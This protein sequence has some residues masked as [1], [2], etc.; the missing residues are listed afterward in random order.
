MEEKRKVEIGDGEKVIEIDQ[1]MMFKAKPKR[2]ERGQ[3]KKNRTA[4]M[5]ELGIVS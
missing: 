3:G 5:E 2:K 1:S 4:K